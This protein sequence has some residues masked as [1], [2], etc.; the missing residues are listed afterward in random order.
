MAGP[1]NVGILALLIALPALQ[2]QEATR[3][4]DRTDLEKLQAGGT[5]YGL[6]MVPADLQGK[7]VVWRTWAG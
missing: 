2:G 5:V 3:T 7:V 6:P 4:D 1:L